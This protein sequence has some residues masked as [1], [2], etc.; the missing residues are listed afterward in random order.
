ITED[1]TLNAAERGGDMLAVTGKVSGEVAVGDTVT[2][3]LGSSVYTG[4]V[5]ELADGALGYSINV[6]TGDLADNTQISASVSH[7]DAAGNTGSA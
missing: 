2:L 6:G 4:E 7:T 1:N 5:I 3:N